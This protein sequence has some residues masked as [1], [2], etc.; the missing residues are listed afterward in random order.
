MMEGSVGRTRGPKGLPPG[1]VALDVRQQG[2]VTVVRFLG[3]PFLDGAEGVA[4]QLLSLVQDAGRC[5]L[6]VNL[7]GVDGMNSAMLGKLITV[8]KKSLPLGGR[9]ALCGV[10][11]K[12]GQIL[13]TVKLS[14]LVGLYNSEEEAVQ[15][16]HMP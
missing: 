10:A 4:E 12:L 7:T 13:E 8:H 3:C 5:R 14:V 1:R 6:V 15:S 11:P 16:F 9:L 2:D